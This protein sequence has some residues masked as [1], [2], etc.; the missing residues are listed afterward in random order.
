M[1]WSEPLNNYCERLGPEFWAE[2]INAISNLSFIIAA[3]FA[4]QLGQ[5]LKVKT[6]GFYWMILTL[7]AIG[8]GSFLFHTFANFWSMYA[9]ILPINLFQLGFIII[10]GGVIG[11]KTG[12]SSI[13][14]SL[15]SLAAFI[16]LTIGFAEFSADTLNGSITYFS[17][18]I[19]L[20]LLGIYHART[21][22]EEQYTLLLA[23]ACFTLSLIFRSFDIVLCDRF[24]IGTHFIWHLLN[25][26][27]LY[28][29]IKAYVGALSVEQKAS[30]EKNN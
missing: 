6:F 5:R 27:V 3:L 16:V 8:I 13:G 23:T 11:R 4:Y 26:Y 25:G 18:Y 14:G 28:L 15:L 22:R 19:S 30:K 24:S 17:A 21:F 10:Y 29:I 9:D 12:I 7:F 2:P 1:N 20:L